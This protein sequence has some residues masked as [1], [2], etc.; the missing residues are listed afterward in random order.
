M[1]GIGRAEPE[2]KQPL[3]ALAAAVK[4]LEEE[5]TP[6][7]SRNQAV[8]W[9]HLHLAAV[10]SRGPEANRAAMER[11]EE[12]AEELEPLPRPQEARAGIPED[13]TAQVSA[14]EP[15]LD[16]AGH[17]AFWLAAAATVVRF[18]S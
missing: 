11:I 1:F 9:A 5:R 6:G 3:R 8:R 7:A 4:V 12:L 14:R 13:R 15:L 2:T 10:L 16:I 18:L 17:L